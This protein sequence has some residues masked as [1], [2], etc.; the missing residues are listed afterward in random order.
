[1]AAFLSL[2]R[3]LYL[4]TYNWILFAGWFQVLFLTLKTLKEPG[5][6]HV[7]SNIQKPL[8]F[9]QTAALLEILH[10]IVGLVR[11]PVSTTVPQISSRLYM[12]WGILYSFPEVQT[13]PLISSLVISWCIAEIVRYA[14]YGTKEAFGSAPYLLLWLRY[15][16]FFVLYPTGIASEIGMIYIALP[17]MKESGLYSVRMPNKWNF[18][19]SYFYVAI[20]VIAVYVPG[21]PHLYNHMLRQRKKTLSKPKEE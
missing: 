1:M 8:L 11:S 18:S 9:A 16:T 15:S 5:H 12:V 6:A 10:C 19:F 4:T 21:V 3:R 7:Y 13:H 17:F 20:G 14:F 2:L